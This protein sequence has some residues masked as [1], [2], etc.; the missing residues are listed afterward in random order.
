MRKGKKTELAAV[1]PVIGSRDPFRCYIPSDVGRPLSE[2]APLADRSLPQECV[3][4]SGRRSRRPLV[5]A[6][7]THAP[8]A[9]FFLLAQSSRNDRH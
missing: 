1:I 9:F 8:L 6:F 3:A 2:I 7:L 4:S 5:Q